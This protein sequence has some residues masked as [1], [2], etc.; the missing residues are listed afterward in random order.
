MAC[1]V[2]AAGVAAKDVALDLLI[3]IAMRGRNRTLASS[4]YCRVRVK[5][6]GADIKQASLKMQPELRYLRMAVQCSGGRQT[7]TA[8][9]HANDSEG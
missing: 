9:P 6:T 3:D 5:Q 4:R 8:S 7:W 2:A 1:V